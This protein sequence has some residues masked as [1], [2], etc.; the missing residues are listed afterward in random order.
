ML[1]WLIES[2]RARGDT[3]VRLHAQT[4]AVAF[5]SKAGFAAL[6]DEFLEAGIPHRI[7]MLML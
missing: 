5:Y 6:G 2:A 4:H 3:V 1:G 7:M